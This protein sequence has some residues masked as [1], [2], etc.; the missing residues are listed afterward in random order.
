[1]FVL[2]IHK[3]RKSGLNVGIKAFFVYIIQSIPYQAICYKWRNSL[4]YH[5]EREQFL[6]IFKK[7]E[8]DIILPWVAD[9]VP[10]YCWV[11]MS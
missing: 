4:W 2:L 5:R 10:M 3:G 8:D 7:Q 1:M 11:P 6:E 9:G